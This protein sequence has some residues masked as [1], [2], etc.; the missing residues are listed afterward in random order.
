MARDSVKLRIGIAGVR[1]GIVGPGRLGQALGRLLHGRGQPVTAVSGRNLSRTS[2]AAQFIGRGVQAVQIAEIPSLASHV[3]ITVPDDALAAVACDLAAV[4]DPITAVLHTSG[5]HG[6]E[7]LAPL[8]EL[9]VSCGTLHPL[10]TI[11]NPEQGV[12]DLP[13]SYF[14]VTA[15][16]PAHD[17]ARDI[18][19]VLHGHLLEIPSERRPL[20][21]AS[22]VMASNYLMAMIDAAVILFEQCG[23]A[24][25]DALHALAPM[26]RSSV[27]NT[28]AS[29]PEKALTG[30]IER[31]DFQTVASHLRAL[32]N[33]SQSVPESIRELYRSA[34]LHAAGLALRKS[35]GTHRQVIEGLLRGEIEP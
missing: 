29:G 25:E 17:W 28:L 22:A 19:E 1:I 33:S 8:Q 16:G 30:P 18:C 21:H 14:G 20:Y 15:S 13:G 6:P 4:P 31:G 2:A 9:G 27:A 34:G 10:Q 23:V 5:A 24:R 35:P 11:A 3:L 7:A 32:N 26:I 12:T